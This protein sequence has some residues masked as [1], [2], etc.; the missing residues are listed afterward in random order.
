M[1]VLKS[2]TTPTLTR[3]PIDANP[4]KSDDASCELAPLGIAP[5]GP[6]LSRFAAKIDR[7]LGT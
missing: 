3:I 1:N 2:A 5:L 6:V 7:R 4:A